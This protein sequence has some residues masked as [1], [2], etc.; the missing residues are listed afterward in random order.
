MYIYAEYF[1]QTIFYYMPVKEIFI[2]AF[3]IENADIY[4]LVYSGSRSLQTSQAFFFSVVGRE[5]NSMRCQFTT[6]SLKKK[7]GTFTF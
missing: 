6:E 4:F 5:T 2:M 7:A 1:K 3:I